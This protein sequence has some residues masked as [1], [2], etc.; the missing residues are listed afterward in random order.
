MSTP[1]YRRRTVRSLALSVLAVGLVAALPLAGAAPSG[2]TGPAADAWTPL[3]PVTVAFSSEVPKAQRA[4]GQLLS[5]NDFHGAIDPPTGSGGLVNGVPAGGSEYLATAVRKLRREAGRTPTLT[6]GAGDMVG[7]SPLVSA[8][9][10]DEPA[11][12]ALSTLGLDINAVGNHE[13]DEGVTELKRLQYGGCH[14]T[15]GC[16]DGD[17]FAGARFRFLAANV[18]DKATRKPIFPAY[19]I[20]SV[21]GVKVGFVGMTLR[22]TP[23]IVNPTGITSVDF[24]DEAETANKYAAELKKRGVHALVLLIHQGGS[25]TGSTAD[26]SG[27][28]GFA[29]DITPIVAKVDPAY[30]VVASG[31]THRFY[32]CALPNS[33]GK[34]S[35]VTSAGTNGVLVTDIDAT[36]DKRAGTFS[37]VSA[38]NVIAENGVRNPDGTWKTDASGAYVRDPAKADPAVKRVADKYRA[39]VA[40]IANEVIGSI[41][42]D[43]TNSNNAAGESALGDVIADAQLRYTTTS[44]SAQIALMNPGG[45]RA[46][47]NYANSPGGEA[48]GQVT[49]GEAFTVQPFNN[50]VVTQT[51]TGQQLKDVL[52]Q[53]FVGF[54][55]QTT[56]RILQVSAGFTFSYDTRA[57]AGS[58]ITTMTLNGAPIDLATSYRVTTNDFLANG[59]DGFTNLTEGTAR[60][61]APG[62]DIDA[63]TAYLGAGTPI[64]PGPQNRITKLG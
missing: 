15:D 13:F 22:G 58:R 45:I 18:V 41:T 60:A 3:S 40:P 54:D 61:T 33:S 6:V 44:A 32:S 55:G 36:F 63:L 11:I 56:Q 9:F 39:A 37:T 20:R 34:T 35:V 16:Q 49:Y 30:G 46:S 29:G 17:G 23:S 25:Q 43:I 14:P 12:E 31:H 28:A 26:P 52:E 7:A 5:F 64:A 1:L 2:T 62:F 27:C 51:F 24:L 48:P 57:A 21:G 47:L 38:R 8:A 50:L 4:T 42:A 59:G 10:H 53:Q 19:T